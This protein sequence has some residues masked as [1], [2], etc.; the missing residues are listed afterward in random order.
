[1]GVCAQEDCTDVT[2]LTGGQGPYS[3]ACTQIAS[4]RR[5]VPKG[6]GRAASDQ[7]RLSSAHGRPASGTF[8]L[9]G[10][11]VSQTVGLPWLGIV[12]ARESR[13]STSTTDTLDNYNGGP[14]E[15]V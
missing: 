13:L 10:N 2:F 7:R 11:H 8:W 4:W 15:S 3:C 6:A 12:S 5:R 1:M 9:T 14:C